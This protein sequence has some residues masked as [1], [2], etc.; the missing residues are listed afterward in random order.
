MTAIWGACKAIFD[1]FT[2]YAARTQQEQSGRAPGTSNETR[3]THTEE[4]TETNTKDRQ[5]RRN[6]PR[7]GRRNE[8][9]KGKMK[10]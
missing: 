7:E 5:N 3:S 1:H 9:R 4:D 6:E 8:P 10:V 2:R